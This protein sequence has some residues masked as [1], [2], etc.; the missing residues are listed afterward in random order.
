[1]AKCTLI[2]YLDE[3]AMES[4]NDMRNDQPTKERLHYFDTVLEGSVESNAALL[5]KLYNDIISRSNIDFGQ[6]PDSQGTLIKY[7]GYPLMS[8]SMDN[9]NKLFE[10]YKCDELVLMNKLHDLI[11]TCKKDYELGY[12]FDIEIVKIAYCTAVMTLYELINICILAYTRQMR[13]NASIEFAFKT[14]KKKD[15]IVIRGAKS[16]LKSY[17]TGQW[18]KMMNEFKKDPAFMG[19]GRVVGTTATEGAFFDTVRNTIGAL[20]SRKFGDKVAGVAQVISD[21]PNLI[22]VPAAIL[23]ALITILIAIRGLVFVFYSGSSKLR[24]YVKNQKEFVDITVKQ[25]QDEG[26]NT[27][28]LEFHSKLSQKLEGLATF[29]EV[30]LLKSNADATKELSVSNKENYSTQEIRTTMNA[31]SDSSV[32]EF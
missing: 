3:Y 10:G 9:L 25:E 19:V 28:G 12:K 27:K 4:F 1:M 16:L 21:V 23:A 24:D 7:K 5:Q 2:Q 8:E 6:I 32:I 20:A 17:E 18:T 14:I 22:K 30:H 13:K 11:V 31:M 29:I 26:T 15:V